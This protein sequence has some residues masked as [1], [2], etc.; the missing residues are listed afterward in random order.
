M[1]P[2]AQPPPPPEVHVEL[3]PAVVATQL[4]ERRQFETT[5]AISRQRVGAVEAVGWRCVLAEK[6][7][8][9]DPKGWNERNGIK[10]PYYVYVKLIT[11]NRAIPQL[12]LKVPIDAKTT[13]NMLKQ[14]IK[15][16]AAKQLLHP[17][18]EAWFAP[19]CQKLYAFGKEIDCS[20]EFNALAKDQGIQHGCS[21]HISLQTPAPHSDMNPSMI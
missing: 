15:A 6:E 7:K 4:E 19:S 20:D 14:S 5:E 1:P 9:L 21:I 8:R 17:A 16:E 2:K 10:G 13:L 3:D 11:G 18:L 12:N